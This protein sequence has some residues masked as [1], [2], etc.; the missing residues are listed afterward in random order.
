MA[1]VALFLV[2][3]GFNYLKVNLPQSSITN[4]QGNLS[5]ES[6][7]DWDNDGLNNRDESYWNTDPNNSD[8]D[9]D[10]Y[11][12]G[13]EVASSHDPLITGPDDLIN[14]GNI[15][16]EFSKLTL[17]GL[18]EG[19]LKPGSPNYDKSIDDLTLA[20][21]DDARQGFQKNLNNLS[22]RMT[23]SDRETQ[24]IYIK[25]FS[26]LFKKL[27]IDYF[28][29]M[30]HFEKNLNTIGSAGFGEPD[31]VKYFQSKTTEFQ[32]V[33]NNALQ[34]YVPKN[35]AQSHLGFLKIAGELTEINR[36]VSSGSED[37]LKATIA[38]SKLVIFL[39]VIPEL[40]QS[41]LDKISEQGLNV[42]STIFEK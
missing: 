39:D 14:S 21:I 36:S 4:Q 28:E 26:K 27:A 2:I 29:E 9:G 31:M 13:E 10:G 7:A 17:S 18:Y 12:D 33:F 37:P 34:A 1:L 19:S 23:N 16:Q 42:K 22:I 25:N 8:T 35:W 32:E 15:T 11:F 24:E 40:T 6:D 30:A 5:L 3:V 20:V 41:Y 38:L